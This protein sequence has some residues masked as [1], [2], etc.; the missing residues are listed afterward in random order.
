MNKTP[1][2]AR[3]VV[4]GFAAAAAAALTAVAFALLPATGVPAA[5][6]PNAFLIG[7][8][9]G[10]YA[11]AAN[12]LLVGVFF[13]GNEGRIFYTS[14]QGGSTPS[15]QSGAWQEVPGGGRTPWGP[16]VARGQLKTHVAVL[17]N[18]HRMF[19]Q[20]AHDEW[21]GKTWNSGWSLIP[22]TMKFNSAP[23]L[24]SMADGGLLAT[25]RGFDGKMYWQTM[26]KTGAWLGE[27]LPGN[28]PAPLAYGFG[29]A[30]TVVNGRTFFAMTAEDKRVYVGWFHGWGIDWTEVPGGGRAVGTP[31]LA[32][33][34]KATLNV[35]VQGLGNRI[36]YQA[37]TAPAGTAPPTWRAGWTE[38]PGQGQFQGV[39]NGEGPAASTTFAGNLHIYHRG[40]DGSL[41]TIALRNPPGSTALDY[42][43][44]YQAWQQVPGSQVSYPTNPPTTPPTTPPSGPPSPPPGKPDLGF[45]G[46]PHIDSSEKRMYITFKNVGNAN[47]GGFRVHLLINGTTLYDYWIFS[48][49]SPGATQTIYADVSPLSN[50]DSYNFVLDPYGAVNESNAQNNSYNGYLGTVQVVP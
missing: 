16:A 40:L 5:P 36:H 26:S 46:T 8:G 31:A 11:F 50:S 6:I 1:N 7:A 19:L 4:R 43:E 42:A 37:A 41:F 22:G 34:G 17:G 13:A 45:T 18:D 49:M 10:T 33:T 30:T 14:G 38:V 39:V 32:R 2:R 3:H 25:A 47:A 24:A 27:W 9:S 23:S 20:T 35:I 12:D 44:G 28:T 15:W 48:S 29:I 21:G